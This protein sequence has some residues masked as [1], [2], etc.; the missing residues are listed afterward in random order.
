MASITTLPTEVVEL[1]LWSL[2]IKDLLFSQRTFSRWRSIVKRSERL[3]Q[4]LFLKPEKPRLIAHYV[5]ICR[6]GQPDKET[7][8]LVPATPAATR[9]SLA[10]NRPGRTS[11]RQEGRVFVGRLNPLLVARTIPPGSFMGYQPSVCWDIA[12]GTTSI[13]CTSLSRYR[14]S[15]RSAVCR[16]MFLTQ[17]PTDAVRCSWRYLM[18]SRGHGGQADALETKKSEI[19]ENS[20]GVT[21]ADILEKIEDLEKGNRADCDFVFD[22]EAA[23][24]GI[25]ELTAREEL[26]VRSIAAQAM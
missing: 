10:R 6:H 18:P 22:S 14:D 21:M 5:N 9:E 8:S 23:V 17:P 20:A 12:S 26:A 2:P 3:Q 25:V 13:T 16:Q 11:Y 1:I 24:V 19:V 7:Y 4:A 15:A